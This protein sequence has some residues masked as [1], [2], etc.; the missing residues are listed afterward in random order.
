MALDETEIAIAG[1]LSALEF[2][3]EVMLANNL[4]TLTKADAD[5]FLADLVSRAPYL[6]KGPV[7]QEVLAAIVGEMQAVL[8]GFAGKVADRSDEIRQRMTE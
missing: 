5:A 1:R 7:D 6:R 3:L 2:V 8:H 4:A